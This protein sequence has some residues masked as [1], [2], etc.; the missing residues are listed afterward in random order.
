M[1]A[2][3][4]ADGERW[5]SRVWRIKQVSAPG[6]IDPQWLGDQLWF[7]AVEGQGGDPASRGGKHRICSTPPQRVRATMDGIADPSPVRFG[8]QLH[9]FVTQLPQRVIQLSGDPLREVRRFDGVE[10]PFAY[11]HA[12]RLHLLAQRAGGG[13]REPLLA[14][15]ADGRSWSAFAAVL[16]P[17]EVGPARPPGQRGPRPLASCTS[18]VMGRLNGAWLLLC[19]EER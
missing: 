14:S 18:P 7:Y 5:S 2:L 17:G 4:T 1:R 11:V 3:T 9:L 6:V 12:G 13:A 10:V 8:G 16:P 19:V 15:S